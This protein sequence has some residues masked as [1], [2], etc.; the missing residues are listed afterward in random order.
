MLGDLRPQCEHKG[1][2]LE[3]PEHQGKYSQSV[4]S[5]TR[6]VVMGGCGDFYFSFSSQLRDCELSP[7]VNRDLCRRVRT[8]NGLTHH[9][10]VVRNDIR[11]SARLVHSLDQRGELWAG[12]VQSSL[13]QLNVWNENK[14]KLLLYQ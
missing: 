2:V 8:V 12:Q 3:P 1:D 10:P 14:S 4:S 11:L 13:Q 5:L 9:K 7:V 6:T